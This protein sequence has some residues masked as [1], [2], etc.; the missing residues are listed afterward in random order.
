ME[1]KTALRILNKVMDAGYNEEKSILALTTEKI[2]EIKGI[3]VP[4]I[5]GIIELQKAIKANKV[6][7]FLAGETEDGK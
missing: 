1:K 7:T 5:A 6:I 3:T 2:L 4:E